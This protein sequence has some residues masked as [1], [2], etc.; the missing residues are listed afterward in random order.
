MALSHHFRV[1]F[2]LFVNK[3]LTTASEPGVLGFVKGGQQAGRWW[4]LTPLPL[5][6]P[7]KDRREVETRNLLLLLLLLPCDVVLFP[8]TYV[9]SI[10]NGHRSFCLCPGGFWE[11]ADAAERRSRYLV[12]YVRRCASFVHDFTMFILCLFV[13]LKECVCVLSCKFIFVHLCSF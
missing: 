13:C 10:M 1:H 3:A 11:I 12:S 6:Y 5:P 8:R 7:G 9:S 2:N 4:W